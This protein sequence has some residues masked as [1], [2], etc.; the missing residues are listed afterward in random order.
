[1]IPYASEIWRTPV[2]MVLQDKQ[3]LINKTKIRLKKQNKNSKEK[4][5]YRY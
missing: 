4:N 3:S 5:I 2:R 1:M